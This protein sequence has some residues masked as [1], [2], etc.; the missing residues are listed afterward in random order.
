MYDV[1]MLFV[2][3]KA[4][5]YKLKDTSEWL[6]ASL[7]DATSMLT[8]SLMG[9]PNVPYTGSSVTVVADDETKD[10][11]D[12]AVTVPTTITLT[13]NR[14]PRA[15]KD[16][17]V[18]AT[19]FANLEPDGTGNPTLHHDVPLVA[20]GVQGGDPTI[21]GGAPTLKTRNVVVVG[22]QHPVMEPV[23]ASPIDPVVRKFNYGVP[24]VGGHFQD[25]D[26][27]TYAYQVHESAKS[28]HVMLQDKDGKATIRGLK[29]TW[30]AKTD[31]HEPV[32]VNVTAKD[33][34]DVELQRLS[35]FAVVVDG[36]PHIK[37]NGILRDVTIGIDQDE[38]S[39]AVIMLNHF[40]DG[41][42]HFVD[43]EERRLYYTAQSTD[44][45]V[46]QVAIDQGN[47]ETEVSNDLPDGDPARVSVSA[48]SVGT[49]TVTVMASTVPRLD[50][51]NLMVNAT[52]RSGASG[53]EGLGQKVYD[54][55]EVTVVAD[56]DD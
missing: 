52:D 4:R 15:G 14:K 46:I 11:D 56:R 35:V 36:A 2:G 23:S 19:A 34:G 29:S 9:D 30:N 42:A 22:T 47:P 38:A 40:I 51:G 13:R 44:P 45:S 10:D 27:L 18:A 53:D 50:N 8:V 5:T 16:L 55:F 33:S 31:V 26:K 49:A 39:P 28:V 43:P 37:G 7:D 6:T 21:D 32:V 20:T 12:K 48:R 1:S 17:V 41:N 3:S 25:D 24:E 54:T